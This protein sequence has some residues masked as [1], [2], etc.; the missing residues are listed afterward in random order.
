MSPTSYPYDPHVEIRQKLDEEINQLETR[1]IKLK[2]TRND[3]APVTRLHPEI[4][5]EIFFLAHYSSE[6][7]GKES[8]LITWVSH[9]WRELAHN[10]SAL[11]SQIDFKHPEWVE[12]ALSRTK[13]RELEI[14]LDGTPRRVRHNFASLIPFTLGN[15]SRIR[16]L[17]ITARYARTSFPVDT[18]EWLSPAPRLVNLHLRGLT[19]PPNL[20]S[21]TAPCLR[22]LYLSSC[23]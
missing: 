2:L 19:L 22:S 9:K 11:W 23:T 15:L 14:T 13:H 16:K 18:P 3:L 1:L 21:G 17:K 20:F 7:K 10:T 8:L 4:L 5:Q 12:V 6:R